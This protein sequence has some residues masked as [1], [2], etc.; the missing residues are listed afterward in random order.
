M[1]AQGEA[2]ADAAR[3]GRDRGCAAFARC[4]SATSKGLGLQGHRPHRADPGHFRRA[5]RHAR[6]HAAGRTRASGLPAQPPGA[7]LDPP[8]AAAR[9][10]RLP[11]RPRRD[12][13]RGRPADDRRPH[14]AAK[15]E[16][17]QVRRTRGLHRTAR[18]RVPFPV[19]ALVGY[20]NAGKSTLF[21]AMTGAEVMA[22]DQL[23]RHARPDH[24]RPAAAVRP[25]RHP[26][27]HGRLHQRTA[28]RTGRRVPRHA[29]GSR[30]RP[31]S[32]CTCATSPT[33][34]APPS[35]PT[36]SAC[37]TAWSADGTLDAAWPARTHR[38]AEQGRPARRRRRRSRCATGAV[39]VSA[40]TGEG[41]A[42]L[43]AAID[44]RIAAGMEIADYDH[45]ARRRRAAGVAL[46]AWRGD[47]PR[48]RRRGDPRHRAPAPRGPRPVR[49]AATLNQR[50]AGPA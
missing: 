21:N 24:A 30:R 31:T 17:E 34:T 4:S 1:A 29:G 50:D 2:I 33:P 26:V 35:A 15:S 36:S 13:D 3:R 41:L 27:R 20:T 22:R 6:R 44:A 48:G 49:T 16:L 28:D 12:A 9:R 47:R 42:A 19:V 32:S 25:P 43:R 39:A 23:V 18:R 8:G 7:V 46:R 5:R 37:W 11:R 45:P 38:G 40:I 14:R 10:L